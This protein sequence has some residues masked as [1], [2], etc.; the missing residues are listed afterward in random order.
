M[1]GFFNESGLH[2]D[3]NYTVQA[4]LDMDLDGYLVTENLLENKPTF[5]VERLFWYQNYPD[6][7]RA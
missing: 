1:E 2:Y 7:P 6:R 5:S 4:F 3:K